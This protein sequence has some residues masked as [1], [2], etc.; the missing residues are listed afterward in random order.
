MNFSP[1]FS[2]KTP[3]APSLKKPWFGSVF[4]ILFS[5]KIHSAPPSLDQEF[6]ALRTELAQVYEKIARLEKKARAEQ[7]IT[8]VS[9]EPVM[10]T[11]H[12]H[13]EE[14]GLFNSPAPQDH[15][16][17]DSENERNQAREPRTLSVDGLIDG[18]PPFSHTPVPPGWVVGTVSASALASVPV[19]PHQSRHGTL[20][21]E[22]TVQQAKL[23]LEKRQ[24]QHARHILV[25]L[26]RDPHT[27]EH[28]FALYWLGIL[29]LHEN[30]LETAFSLFSNVYNLCKADPNS[31]IQQLCV[32]ALLRMA[33]TRLR[34]NNVYDATIHYERCQNLAKSMTVPL[35]RHITYGIRKL[36]SALKKLK[37]AN[38]PSATERRSPEEDKGNETR[39]ASLGPAGQTV[40]VPGMESAT[41]T[42]SSLPTSTPLKNMQPA[43]SSPVLISNPSDYPSAQ[44]APVLSSDATED[45][46]Y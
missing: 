39:G 7:P 11:E 14:D 16:S 41:S 1:L 21:P 25:Q 24:M 43:G 10:T 35:P 22:I 32:A 9:R 2:F 18:I 40:A 13:D 26:V 38:T 17:Q 31:E 5:L 23:F 36:R 30:H 3:A 44:A 4:L 12:A 37:K 34:Q 15:E 6:H 45:E 46:S 19:D 33:Q 42:E 29:D 27:K 8:A 28:P 20:S